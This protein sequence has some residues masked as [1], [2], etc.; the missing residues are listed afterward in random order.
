MLIG[1]CHC[2]EPP[3]ESIPP[4]ESV[5]SE[6]IPPSEPPISE[7]FEENRCGYVCASGTFTGK[8]D[9]I[10]LDISN[11]GV[12]TGAWS[13]DVFDEYYTYQPPR[14]IACPDGAPECLC[15]P[16]SVWFEMSDGN[17]YLADICYGS[18]GSLPWEGSTY[19]GVKINGEY[20]QY[21]LSYLYITPGVD[22][23]AW[24][25]ICLPPSLSTIA[26]GTA[27]WLNPT[28]TYC[29]GNPDDIFECTVASCTPTITE[30]KVRYRDQ[31][32]ALG[33]GSVTLTRKY[34]SDLRDNN[35]YKNIGDPDHW[36]TGTGYSELLDVWINNRSSRQWNSGDY[37]ILQGPFESPP[38]FYNDREM[39]D[40]L[41]AE[42]AAGGVNA[43]TQ[44]GYEY[45][46][47]FLGLSKSSCAYIAWSE[48]ETHIS[49]MS[50]SGH[51]FGLTS[52]PKY[53]YSDDVLN[54]FRIAMS[55]LGRP[56]IGHFEAFNAYNWQWFLG[57]YQLSSSSSGNALWEYDDARYVRPNFP[58]P[59]KRAFNW[60]GVSGY[61]GVNPAFC[62]LVKN[63]TEWTAEAAAGMA[64]AFS[65][66]SI[67]TSCDVCYDG[68]PWGVYNALFLEA[69]AQTNAPNTI[70][71]GS[72]NSG[73]KWIGGHLWVNC[74]VS[75]GNRDE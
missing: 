59:A 66:I 12:S 48:D 19:I 39:F 4:S 71:T 35:T 8:S 16:C 70:Y 28:L 56:P 74:T 38:D 5:P 72:R 42:D 25:I 24:C 67:P 1:C 14:Y 54:I 6:S 37:S 43:S 57:E 27:G 34:Y 44:S 2:G 10:I 41:L 47:G 60:I 58:L 33:G 13:S 17:W 49:I 22:Y 69:G 53:K 65:A 62:D 75:W 63:R 40:D 55:N 51:I 36:L 61:D 3:S 9:T 46:I 64:K 7:S 18:D 31:R 15:D 23:E 45:P 30:A 21:P 20:I 50:Y 32:R 68:D 52:Y 29:G 73:T 11:D 26:D